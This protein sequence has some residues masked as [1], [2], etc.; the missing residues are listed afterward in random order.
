[1][2]YRYN[3]HNGVRRI[4]NNTKKYVTG[5]AIS[6]G[7]AGAVTVPVLAAQPTTPGCFGSDRAAYAKAN[8]SLGSD[9]GGVG[10]YA[11]QRAGDNGTINQNYKTGCGGDPVTN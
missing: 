3:V 8:G 10:Y 5:L 2:K 9:P 11:S 6:I 4:K 7:V 1:M